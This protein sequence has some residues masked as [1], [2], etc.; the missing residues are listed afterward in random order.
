MANQRYGKKTYMQLGMVL[1][2]QHPEVAESLLS[3]CQ[4]NP[5]V[6]LDRLPDYFKRYCEICKINPLDHIGKLPD[7]SKSARIRRVFIAVMLTTFDEKVFHQS[8]LAP[9]V[10]RGFVKK[11]GE[12]LSIKPSWVSQIIRQVMFEERIYPEF[13]QEVNRIVT[14]L[15]TIDYGK[16]EKGKSERPAL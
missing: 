10:R 13:A 12:L 3:F 16:T 14:K 1:M 2:K 7:R 9:I 15:K 4:T 6:N 8:E 11:M 5:D